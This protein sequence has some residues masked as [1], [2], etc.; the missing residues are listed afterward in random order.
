MIKTYEVKSNFSNMRLH[1]WYKKNICHVPQSLL[2]KNIRKGKI[3]VNKQKKKGFYKL[4]I[5]DKITINNL[6]GKYTAFAKL[7]E[8]L[9]AIVLGKISPNIIKTKETIRT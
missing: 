2:E 6:S 3:K 7:L 1:R 5:N 4:Q 9:T 8:N